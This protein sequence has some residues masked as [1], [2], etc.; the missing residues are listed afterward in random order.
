MSQESI[1]EKAQALLKEPREILDIP[2]Q[3]AVS[4]LGVD[5]LTIGH[6]FFHMPEYFRYPRN[7]YLTF[8]S[9]AAKDIDG[10]Y[11]SPIFQSD[12]YNGIKPL[13]Q[14]FREAYEK[15]TNQQVDH[16]FF[17]VWTHIDED[18]SFFPVFN[19]ISEDVGWIF[20][21]NVK[22][23]ISIA[24]LTEK[25]ICRYQ[26][27][28]EELRLNRAIRIIK[29]REARIESRTYRENA[30][31]YL[32]NRYNAPTDRFNFGEESF[33]FRQFNIEFL[34]I[35]SELMRFDDFYRENYLPYRFDEKTE[36]EWREKS[37]KLN[38]MLMSSGM[39][40]QDFLLSHAG[41]FKFSFRRDGCIVESDMIDE[42]TGKQFRK[43]ILSQDDDKILEALEKELTR[44]FERKRQ[45]RRAGAILHNLAVSQ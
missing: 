2:I 25:D 28:L 8:T 32:K 10:N 40:R 23:D 17:G 41:P 9:K 45:I 44:I 39:F 13:W 14:E 37:K 22:G 26:T 30:I 43:V 1:K 27:M 4:A 12:R 36:E 19:E 6:N 11:D 24:R 42:Q 16:V 7:I 31:E 35:S 33:K 34:Y 18:D 20:V 38:E 15:E 5:A 29:E 21:K 3:R